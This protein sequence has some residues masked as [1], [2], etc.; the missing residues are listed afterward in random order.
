MSPRVLDA[1]GQ[2]DRDLRGRVLASE[3]FDGEG[4][5]VADGGAVFRRLFGRRE[6]VEDR[7]HAAVVERQGTEPIGVP[8]EGDDADQVV[9][10]AF[11]E[12]SAALHEILEDALHNVEAARAGIPADEVPRLHRP[13]AVDHDRDRDALPLDLAHRIARP[14]PRERDRERE[15][16]EGEKQGREPDEPFAQRAASALDEREARKRDVRPAPVDLEE[17]VGREE[18]GEQEPGIAELEAGEVRH[19]APPRRA[20]PDRPAPRDRARARRRGCPRGIA[21]QRRST[22]RRP[23]PPVDSRRT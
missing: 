23:R 11:A 15:G 3:S 21:P 9:G 20:S 10:P 13:R 14:R 2:Q 5:A 22:D 1:V 8:R 12:A 4:E 19:R 7:E 6:L 16:R 18:P 17:H